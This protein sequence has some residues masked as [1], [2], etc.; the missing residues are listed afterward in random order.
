MADITLTGV[1]IGFGSPTWDPEV[2]VGDAGFGA[3]ESIFVNGN[4]YFNKA[5]EGFG[6]PDSYLELILQDG[7]G[8]N[9][10][11]AGGEILELRGNFSSIYQFFDI[12]LES[13]LM[14]IGPFFLEF[15]SVSDSTLKYNCF[16]AVSG[17][18]TGIFTYTNQRQLMFS[19][20]SMKKGQYTLRVK[21]GTTSRYFDMPQVWTVIHRMR[22]DTTLS[23]KSNLPEYWNAGA[24]TD[25]IE[26]GIQYYPNSESVIGMLV[27]AVGET[28]N[29]VYERDYTICT[30]QAEYDDTTVNVESTLTFPSSG[31]AYTNNDQTFTYTGKTSTSLTGVSGLTD[32]I[33]KNS[34]VFKKDQKLAETDLYYKLQNNGFYKPTIG[35]PESDFEDAMNAIELNERSSERVIFEYLYRL[36]KAVNLNKTANISG[37]TISAPTEGSWNNAHQQ[38]I[39]KIGNRFF[40]IMSGDKTAQEL[41]L[42]ELGCEYWNGSTSAEQE[43]PNGFV[44]G[45]YNIEILPWGIYVDNDGIFRIKMERALFANSTGHI[46]R[47]YI[48]YNIF[49]DALDVDNTYNRNLNLDLFVASG[50]KDEI[51]LERHT[52][53]DEFGTYF[54]TNDYTPTITIQPERDLN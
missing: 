32:I 24:R 22:Y 41:Y 39:C 3:P 34:R 38:R 28:F 10:S 45:E 43:R 54:Y 36:F 14:P 27:S 23:I 46:D 47:D 16:S 30:S 50:I 53:G 1:E 7:N 9:L 6:D 49:L 25:K 4:S 29:Y 13:R 12:D 18:G 52:S 21:Y 44:A 37:N 5:E 11:D 51:V 48:D 2:S 40:F 26:T 19:T 33:T 42:D 8:F 17:L 31:T 15:R 35:I 20:P